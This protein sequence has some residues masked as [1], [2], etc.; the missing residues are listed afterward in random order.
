[1]SPTDTLSPSVPVPCVGGPP[2]PRMLRLRRLLIRQPLGSAAFQRFQ[3]YYELIRLLRIHRPRS[4]CKTS[5]GFTAI[6]RNAQTSQVRL[7]YLCAL[8]T[9]LD[10]GG[11]STALL[12][13]RFL[14]S[15]VHGNTS[16]SALYY[17]RGCIAS[18]FRIAVLALHCLRLNLTSR[19]WLQGCV[20]AACCGFTGAGLSPAC[21][22]S[23][24]LAHS[25]VV[26][27]HIHYS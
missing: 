16:T 3:L 2:V 11:I 14:L 25:I 20:P 24:E 27:Y 1:M 8:T 15:A 12:S 17:L 21:I 19:L 9:L 7:I 13:G 26:L 6:S 23:A 10:P 5:L 22:S 4:I 18:R